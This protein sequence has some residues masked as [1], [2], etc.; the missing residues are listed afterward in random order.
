MRLTPLH[1]GRAALMASV[2]QPAM[3]GL[4]IP[5]SLAA[6]FQGARYNVPD[7]FQRTEAVLLTDPWD[8]QFT[9]NR[10][11]AS[12]TQAYWSAGGGTYITVEHAMGLPPR[13]VEMNF[14]PETMPFLFGTNDAGIPIDKNG[15]VIPGDRR[16]F[17]IDA[18]TETAH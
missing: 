18:K 7:G 12:Y 15:V 11:L 9:G 17:A 1:V 4:G 2:C 13:T 14:D 5:G 3:I 8:P 16:F 6:E 10:Q